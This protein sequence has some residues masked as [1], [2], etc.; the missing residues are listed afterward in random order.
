MLLEMKTEK[1]MRCAVSISTKLLKR[2][3]HPVSVLQL[4][5]GVPISTIPTLSYIDPIWVSLHFD[6][7]TNLSELYKLFEK[8]LKGHIQNLNENST[9]R[10]AI[11]FA[12]GYYWSRL[13][14]V[15][16]FIVNCECFC[17][18]TAVV[19]NF[20]R[21]RI[22]V[23]LAVNLDF[24]CRV[25]AFLVDHG[26]AGELFLGHQARPDHDSKKSPL[27]TPDVHIANPGS[28]WGSAQP[29]LPIINSSFR[30]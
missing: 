5:L 22:R 29:V 13:G 30:L 9:E 4:R 16:V 3:H 7:F 15:C 20:R 8:Y 21:S 1:V 23:Q 10:P 18:G 17:T 24:F 11:C 26:R 27:P 14:A 19:H 25:A 28:I 2:P 6:F 12:P